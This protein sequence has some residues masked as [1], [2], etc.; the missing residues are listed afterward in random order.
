VTELF[1]GQCSSSGTCYL[2]PV[3]GRISIAWRS[4]FNL[5]SGNG[6]SQERKES[7]NCDELKLEGKKEKIRCKNILNEKSVSNS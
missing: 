5:H 2:S 4:Y 7:F 3:C 6:H 1:R